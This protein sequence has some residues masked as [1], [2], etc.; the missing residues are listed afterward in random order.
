MVPLSYWSLGWIINRNWQNQ[1]KLECLVLT[2]V[3]AN[4]LLLRFCYPSSGCLG[5]R[6]RTQEI[7]SRPYGTN[8]SSDWQTDHFSSESP[9]FTVQ[10]PHDPD[11]DPQYRWGCYPDR[12]WWKYR[13]FLPKSYWYSPES[14]PE[15]CINQT[16]S[17]GTWNDHIW[18][19]EPSST[20]HFS[21]SPF[22]SRHWSG[23]TEW[24]FWLNLAGPIIHWW[25]VVDIDSLSWG[26]WG[27]NN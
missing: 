22:A 21:S 2:S 7:S 19:E 26:Y 9:V 15:R 20:R 12:R 4:F 16:S 6:R 27:P 3:Q 10:L 5:L 13:A 24:I 25:G 18:F 8:T 17:L 11:L 23:P 14:W 1:W